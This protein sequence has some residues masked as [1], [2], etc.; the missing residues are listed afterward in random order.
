MCAGK[1]CTFLPGK[2]R[3]SEITRTKT[4]TKQGIIR[5]IRGPKKIDLCQANVMSSLKTLQY[6]VM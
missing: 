2:E 1:C 3:K 6:C 5:A 4:P